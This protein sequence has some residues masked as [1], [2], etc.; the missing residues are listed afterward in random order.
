MKNIL[1]YAP[2]IIAAFILLQTLYYKFGI[3]GIEALN[4]SKEIFGT[5]AEA[6]LGS[7]EYE[8]Y[9]RIGTGVLELATSILLLLNRT[10]IFG[11][12]LGAG[13]MGGALLSHILFIGVIVGE[14][15]GQLFTM[16][17]IVLLCSLKVAYDEKENFFSLLNKD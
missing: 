4:E 17:L 6:A 5:I 3:G 1:K 13:L 10:A 12:L 16:A 7:A 8:S 2:R 15:G 9:M 14:D 11:A